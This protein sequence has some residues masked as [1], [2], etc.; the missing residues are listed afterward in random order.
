MTARDVCR[1][2][3]C[4]RPTLYQRMRTQPHFPKP[5]YPGAAL[6]PVAGR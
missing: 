5:I 6:A 4:A 2:L 1:V 3:R